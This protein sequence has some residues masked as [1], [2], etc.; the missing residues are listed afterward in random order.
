MGM[1]R[2]IRTS[3]STI[4]IFFILLAPLFL[5][6]DPHSFTSC[7]SNATQ[8]ESVDHNI[9]FPFF[10]LPCKIVNLNTEFCGIVRQEN[11]LRT[12]GEIIANGKES[13]IGWMQLPDHLHVGEEGG[14]SRIPDIDANSLHLVAIMSREIV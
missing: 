6:F 10:I 7:F 9:F 12:H 5:S 14:I 2:K 8:Y 13:E 4:D 11:I 3:E 1:K